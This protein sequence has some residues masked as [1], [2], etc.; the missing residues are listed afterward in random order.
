MHKVKLSRIILILLAFSI[1]SKADVI[2]SPYTEVGVLWSLEGIG[3]YE[4]PF[5]GRNTINLWGG[6]GLVTALGEIKHPA[7]GGEAALELRHYFKKD[8]FEGFNLGIYSGIAIMRYPGI[9][10]GQVAWHDTSVGIVPG[11][12]LAYKH[13]IN[14][15]LIGEP[16]IGISA[17]WYEDNLKEVYENISGTEPGLILTV[18]LRIG[19]NKVKLRK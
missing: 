2:F 9:Y 16:Y 19:F 14:S 13:R 17:P 11:F 4:F 10:K 7:F 5:S 3:S 15:W 6:G 18:G 12:K 1:Q 8:K